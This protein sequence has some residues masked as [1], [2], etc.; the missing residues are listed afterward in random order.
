MPLAYSIIEIYT[1]ERARY[2]GR[3]VWEAAVD[4]VLKA[5]TAAR[6]LVFK[7]VAGGYEDGEPVGGHL[8]VLSYDLPVKVEIVVPSAECGRL[9]RAL[10]TVVT[11]GILTVRQADV[12]VHHIKDRLIPRRLR[13]RD[14]MTS[15]V[16]SVA[17]AAPVSDVV[18]LLLGARFN[19]V[20]VVDEANR[21]VGIITQGDLIDR[22]HMPVRLGLLAELEQ[23]P[24]HEYLQSIEHLDAGLVM[25]RPVVTIGDEELLD[26]AVS[27]MLRHGLKRMPVVDGAGLLVGMLAR[28]D[29]LG[30]VAGREAEIPAGGDP[31]VD[32]SQAA[33]VGDIMTRERA[34]IA[35]E[36][37]AADVVTALRARGVQR[38]A[39]VDADDHLL[40]I[41]TDLD[42][43]RALPGRRGGLWDLFARRSDM[44]AA[45]QNKSVTD[46][47]TKDLVTVTE[48][49]NIED[50]IRLM[51]RHG[52]KRLPVVDAENR[53]QGMISR[54]AVLAAG[55]RSGA[56]GMWE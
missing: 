6:C 8:E 1:A 26:A 43:F 51:A 55:A 13:V 20:P 23:E 9:L 30:M 29:V 46:I 35:P 22:A 32:P 4:H 12:R 7:G 34:T 45:A 47:M 39:V 18:R 49:T 15:P 33:A 16:T 17:L 28:A 53:F 41:V 31:P 37:T 42:V 44:W 48:L 21:P 19:S 3:P 52:L 56:E 36:A 24:L 50:A 11:D 2:Q 14:V 10:E 25:S 40:G 38:L 5:G 54:Q 27:Q